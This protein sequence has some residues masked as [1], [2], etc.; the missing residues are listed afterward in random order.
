MTTYLLSWNPKIWEWVDMKEDIA[1]VAKNG[2]FEMQWSTGVTKKIK[3]GD[4]LFL[5]KL[6]VEPRG[7]VASGWAT[8]DVQHSTHYKNSSKKALYIGV[9]F[10]TILSPTAVFPIEFLQ[11]DTFYR[12][13]HWTPQASG[14]CVPDD[15]AERLEKDWSKFLNQP[16]LI[17]DIKYADEV[18][19]TK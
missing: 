3:E 5:M 6:G 2:Y 19:F 12:K 4:R 1:K 14:M 15:I 16:L 13:V 17:S 10:D 8:S 7:I 18:D 9:R 11:N